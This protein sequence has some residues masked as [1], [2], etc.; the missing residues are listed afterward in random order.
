MS[1]IHIQGLQKTFG[2]DQALD[3]LDLTVQPNMVFGFLGPNGAGK[4]TTIRI[5][6][7][8]ARPTE[9][10]AWVLGKDVVTAHHEIA[11][12]IGYLPEEP[13]FYPWMRAGELLETGQRW[14]VKP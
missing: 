9:G 7:G 13:N 8:L 2:R 6:A 4:T 1:A 5:L 11:G 3:G 10:R 14:E 12:R